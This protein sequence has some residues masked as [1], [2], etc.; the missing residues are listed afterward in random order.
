MQN[1]EINARVCVKLVAYKIIFSVAGPRNSRRRSGFG[2]FKRS[3][4]MRGA[5]HGNLRHFERTENTRR[6][7]IE[8][9]QNHV[10]IATEKK[11]NNCIFTETNQNRTGRQRT[12]GKTKAAQR[13]NDSARAENAT[14]R[15]AGGPN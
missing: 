3:R 4:R 8:R 5:M 6:R 12:G 15:D 13:K 1:S 9:K 14:N 7:T 10:V 11:K 2:S